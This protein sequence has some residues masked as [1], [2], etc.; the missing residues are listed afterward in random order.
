MQGVD[1]LTIAE[2]FGHKDLKMTKRYA[3][4]APA[5]R[6]AAVGLLERAY[7]QGTPAESEY[8]VALGWQQKRQQALETPLLA[9]S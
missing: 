4:V 8:P 3:H 7:N 1:L 2:I 6:L 5:H 9:V